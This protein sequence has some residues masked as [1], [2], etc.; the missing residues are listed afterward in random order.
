[1]NNSYELLK[2]LVQDESNRLREMFSN[3]QI[4]EEF[5]N[6]QI[7]YIEQPIINET[8]NFRDRI[9]AFKEDQ[10]FFGEFSVWLLHQN[11]R[12]LKST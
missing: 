10:Y 8:K 11:N 2:Q 5:F 9:F 1:M 7:V 3:G 4:E 6:K 12:T